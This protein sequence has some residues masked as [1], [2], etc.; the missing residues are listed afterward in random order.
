M[1]TILL[2]IGLFS[3]A[4]GL[5]LL[6]WKIRR[7]KKQR[8]ALL[9]VFFSTLLVGLLIVS[10]LRLTHTLPELLNSNDIWGYLHLTLFFSA[11]ALSYIVTYSG[12]EVD[13]PSLVILLAIGERDKEGIEKETLL[14]RFTDERLLRPRLNYL[15]VDQKISLNQG[16]YHI[17]SRGIALLTPILIYRKLTKIGKGG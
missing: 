16:R 17:S 10:A 9:V 14:A 6:A 11:L 13:S 5:H 3:C 15:L 4:F 7:P 1:S 12:I 8:K 2:G